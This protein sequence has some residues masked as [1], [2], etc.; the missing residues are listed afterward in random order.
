MDDNQVLSEEQVMNGFHAFL[1]SALRHA[2]VERLLDDELL[3]SA[4]ADLMICGPAL[5]LYFAALRSNTNPPGVPLPRSRG[6]NEPQKRLTAATCPPSFGPF[7]ELWARAVPRIQS[8]APE[9]TYDLASII[10]GKAPVTL[11]TEIPSPFPESPTPEQA[12]LAKV[13][14]IAADL[15]AV[16]IEI[17][18]RRT[19]QLRYQEDLQAALNL[20]D[21]TNPGG[22][23]GTPATAKF[24]PPPGYEEAAASPPPPPP[25]NGKQHDDIE[26]G[27][28]SPPL[29][30]PSYGY[31]LNVPGSPSS[32][33]P[34]RA[35]SRQSS[36]ERRYAALPPLPP[37]SSDQGEETFVG[38][39]ALSGSPRSP[40]G[41]GG[42]F[43]SMPPASPGPNGWAPLK[44][45]LPQRAS[46]P[47]PV[48]IATPHGHR[49]TQSATLAVP[50]PSSVS[51]R[52]ASPSLLTPNDPSITI[53]R[54]TLYAGLA[55]A[56][57]ESP[58][59]LDLLDT[60]PPR[61]YFA[62]VALAILNVSLTSVT[63]SGSIRAVLGQELT[64]DTCPPPL[65]PLMAEFAAIGENTKEIAQEDNRRAMYLAERGRDI[66]EPRIDRLKRTLQTGV[67]VQRQEERAVRRATR[68]EQRER[69]RSPHPR[70]THVNDGG[71]DDISSG[72]SDEG[73]Q[74]PS[75][76]TV[77]F[78][79]RINELALRMTSLPAFRERQQEVFAILKSVRE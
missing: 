7:F 20:G 73:R 60:D 45:N 67:A 39:F 58:R 42:G 9:H 2:K 17:S 16:A 44:V 32:P 74:S 50:G 11:P 69:G 8:L 54:E 63:P 68:R 26:Y 25:M 49:P 1:V 78:A 15:R 24:V 31:S 46:T 52:P 30:S 64:L 75:S 37:G 43:G 55:D 38:G 33:P 51:A 29:K 27:P 47:V 36:T 35:H 41:I 14:A 40:V 79:N 5:C 66:P 59:L 22:P 28:V 76:S 57:S 4:E 53:I 48:R 3:A 18:Q 62:A 70:G 77:R 6:S 21:P 13:H 23:R 56:L 19:F 71:G 34:S 72:S 61:A 12:A 65:R 10:C